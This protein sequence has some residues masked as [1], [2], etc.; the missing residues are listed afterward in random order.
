MD[1]VTVRNM[2]L[3]VNLLNKGV[4]LYY[5]NNYILGESNTVYKR[6]LSPDYLDGV[7]EFRRSVTKRP[8]PSP[9]Q[10]STSLVQSE[11]ETAH[12]ITSVVGQWWQ[13]IEQ[14]L[15]QTAASVQGKLH[16]SHFI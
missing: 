16:F 10:I 14:D 6:L 8:L 9:R 3:E 7:S 1:P 13:F 11:N 12:D 2:A 5:I 4:F 15:S